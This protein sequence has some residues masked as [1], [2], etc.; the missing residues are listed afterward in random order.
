MTIILAKPSGIGSFLSSSRKFTA[1]AC[2]LLKRIPTNEIRLTRRSRDMSSAS[3]PSSGHLHRTQAISWC[4]QS[5][6][7]AWSPARCAISQSKKRRHRFSSVLLT[8]SPCFQLCVHQLVRRR[9][10]WSVQ[11]CHGTG[12]QDRSGRTALHLSNPL[13]LRKS[14]SI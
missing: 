5:E 8:Y 6:K 7:T 3:L 1:I 10:I 14:C 12:A 4:R 11:D 13:D 2:Q 9:R